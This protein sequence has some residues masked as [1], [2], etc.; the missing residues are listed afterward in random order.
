MFVDRRDAGRQLASALLAHPDTLG[1]AQSTG[2]CGG[3][4]TTSWWSSGGA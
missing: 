4:C 3:A 1:D 2:R